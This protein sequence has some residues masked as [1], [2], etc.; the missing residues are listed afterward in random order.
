MGVTIKDIAKKTN[1][2]LSTISRVINKSGYVSEETRMKVE[3]VIREYNYVPSALA[4]HLTKGNNNII[5]VV[6]PEIDNSFYSG[7]IKGINEFADSQGL[8]IIL[9]DTGEDAEKEMRLI[10]EL[11][12]QRIRGLLVT[13]AIRNSQ[14]SIIPGPSIYNQL[15]MPVVLIDRE[16]PGTKFDGIF[17]DDESAI[18]DLTSLLINNNHKHIEMLAG[19]PDLILG[20][21]R[22]RGYKKAFMSYQMEY[23]EDWI[24]YSLFTKEAGYK[25]TMDIIS[26][27]RENWPTAIVANNNMLTLGA[28]MAI[29]EKKLAIPADIALVGYDQIEVL[30]YLKINISLAEK[31]TIEMGRVAMKMLCDKM[32]D[33]KNEN[34]A[35]RIIMMPKLVERGSEKFIGK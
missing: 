14:K 32:S 25:A 20:Q 1:C 15:E 26:R 2:S 30:E 28:L 19:N 27:D 10:S 5:G 21:N 24:H 16:I 29:F 22:A 9:C 17:F 33:K 12:S 4:K 6:I 35:R 18:F 7:V 13:S 31:D 11:R 3:N 8:S 23:K 34:P